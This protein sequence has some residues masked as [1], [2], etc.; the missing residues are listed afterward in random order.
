MKIG[1]L[2]NLG[3]FSTIMHSNLGSDAGLRGQAAEPLQAELE[4]HNKSDPVGIR[5]S[6]S[7]SLSICTYKQSQPSHALYL[8]PAILRTPFPQWRDVIGTCAVHMLVILCL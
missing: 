8:A 2:T 1:T 7:A 3:K 6:D 4:L 5:L